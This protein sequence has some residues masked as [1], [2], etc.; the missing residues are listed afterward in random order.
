MN[1]NS[2]KEY[3]LDL[4][5]PKKCVNCQKEGTWL[6][7]HCLNKIVMVKA[8]SCPNCNR[9]TSMG[10]FCPRCR[11]KTSLTGV[12]TAA[13]YEEGPLKEAIHNFKYNGVRDLVTDLAD[14]LAMRLE[15]GF[16][17][18]RL[19]LVPVP[20]HPKRQ[21]ERGFNQAQELAKKV[22]EYFD[23]E[24]VNCLKRIRETDPQVKKT[25]LERKENVVGAFRLSQDQDQIQNEV[26][27]PEDGASPDIRGKTV[28]L[29][30]DVFTTGTTLS[31]CGRMLRQAGA[32]QV[33][34][35]VLAKV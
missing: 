9:L 12:I 31:E 35:L 4:L 29:V 18:G 28:L 21:G 15:D 25:G 14:I 2:I 1:I 33:W 24:I 22:A 11:I 16:P 32:R 30:D 19:V 5:F 26:P 3:I 10:Q 34:G 27:G 13:H 6:C 20:L 17:N 23:I 7:R 8:P